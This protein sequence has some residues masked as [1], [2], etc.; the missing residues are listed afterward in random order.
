MD[1][2]EE[3][4]GA[5]MWFLWVFICFICASLAEILFTGI[6]AWYTNIF[7]GTKNFISNSNI[8]VDKC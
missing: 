4:S 7:T 5:D 6:Q 1:I 8:S 3:E 2:Q